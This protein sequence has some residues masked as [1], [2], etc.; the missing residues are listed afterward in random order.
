M[1]VG[2]WLVLILAADTRAFTAGIVLPSQ[3]AK[4]AGRMAVFANI[5]QCF[6]RVTPSDEALNE[7]TVQDPCRTASAEALSPRLRHLYVIC[8]RV[9]VRP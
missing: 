6:R 4:R 5:Q 3:L 7:R 9:R 1:P 8:E 2:F